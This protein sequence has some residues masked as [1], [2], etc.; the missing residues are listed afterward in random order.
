MI[1]TTIPFKVTDILVGTCP[2]LDSFSDTST[3]SLSPLPSDSHVAQILNNILFL[4]ITTT[5]QYHAHTRAFLFSLAITFDERNIAATLKH[6]D[7]AIE[8]VQRKAESAKEE[9]A[10]SGRTLRMVGMGLGA[11]AGGAIVGIT[12]GLAAPLIGAGLTTVLSWLGVSGTA[13]GLLA[14][15]LASSSV[16]CGALFGVYGSKKSAEMVDRFTKEVHDLAIIAIHPPEGSLAVR[17]CVSG[18][19]GSREDVTSPWT[20]FEGDDTFALQWV[21][22]DVA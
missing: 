15:G 21:R 1:P 6:P 9:Q 10:A 19:L 11:V 14:S 16:V 18:W 3:A 12:G 5:K 22:D 2:V 20:V 13:V 17:L 7:H 4:H 8:A